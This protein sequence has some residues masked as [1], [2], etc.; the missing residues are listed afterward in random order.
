MSRY[1]RTKL[2]GGTFFFTVTLADRSSD[3]LIQKIDLLRGA[4]AKAQKTHAFK[5]VAICILPDHLHAIWTL[6]AEDDD[7]SVRWNIIKGAF[8]R[9]LPS[10]TERSLSKIAKREK[11]VWQRRFWEHAIRDQ[12]DL[13]R[14][15]DYIHYNPVKH[16]LVTRVS[17]WQHSSFHNFVARGDLPQDW[18]GDTR[19]FSGDFGE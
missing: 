11:G 19:E 2:K 5:T 10:P 18:G 6:P 14:H 1:R 16:R 8:S 7:F 13:A 9:S 4:Y 12:D 15:I 17:D 3:L